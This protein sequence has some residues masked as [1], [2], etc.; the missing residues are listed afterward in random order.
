MQRAALVSGPAL[1]ACRERGYE[2]TAQGK[3]IGVPSS[4]IGLTPSMIDTENTRS[5]GLKPSVPPPPPP[6]RPHKKFDPS[7]K[8][9]AIVHDIC[10]RDCECPDSPRP[11]RRPTSPDPARLFV[12][13]P[14]TSTQDEDAVQLFHRCVFEATEP[15][16]REMPERPRIHRL[17]SCSSEFGL[18]HTPHALTDGSAMY[19]VAQR[20]DLEVGPHQHT[21]SPQFRRGRSGV[22]SGGARIRAALD[23]L[24]HFR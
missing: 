14:T 16:F 6:E 7:A 24:Y 22:R 17:V 9:A 8:V 4:S 21:S 19:H 23:I 1:V 18:T 15:T 5:I 11:L 10:L 3:V 20:H 2:T 13:A 12:G